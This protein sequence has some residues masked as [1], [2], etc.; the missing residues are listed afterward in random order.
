MKKK[1]FYLILSLAAFAVIGS[2]SAASSNYGP[3]ASH[4]DNLI[5]A[6]AEKFNLNK[7]DVQVVFNQVFEEQ[8]TKMKERQEQIFTERIN[9]AVID[10]KLTQ[11]QADK[12]TA[13]RAELEAQREDFKDM[14]G[15]ELKTAM[16]EQA[17]SLKQWASDNNIPQGYLMFGGFRKGNCGMMGFKGQI[18]RQNSSE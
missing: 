12:I 11:E 5:N 6:V 4:M 13:K 1:Y 18:P 9:Q 2:V 3:S 15:E 10:G 7:S 16:K 17:D 14:T 8:R